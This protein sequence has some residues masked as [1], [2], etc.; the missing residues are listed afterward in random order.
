MSFEL[1]D[2]GSKIKEIRHSLYLTQNDVFNSIGLNTETLRRMEGGLVIPK[3]ETLDLLSSAYKID[4]CELFLSYRIKDY[5]TYN[6]VKSRLEE[7]VN[8]QESLNFDEEI[9][10]IET[11]IAGTSNSLYV[12]L[13]NQLKLYYI[14]LRDYRNNF[15]DN[16]MKVCVDAIRIT[17]PEFALE[18]IEDYFYSDTEVKI[19]MLIGLILGQREKYD[20]A[21]LVLTHCKNNVRN[22]LALLKKI[23]SNL[24]IMHLRSKRYEEALK[25]NNDIIEKSRLTNDYS[26]L[27]IVYFNKGICEKKLGVGDYITSFKLALTMNI[28]MDNGK[29][30]EKFIKTLLEDYDIDLT[31]FFHN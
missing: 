18:N 8:T 1:K 21:I 26:F 20:E 22:D 15:F 2:F 14:G 30:N 25:S 5:N 6:L 23:M 11:I 27:N 7:K 4:V 13:L 28:I 17:T 31:N 12:N 16:S 19:L 3:L 24:S 29:L 10:E 9:I